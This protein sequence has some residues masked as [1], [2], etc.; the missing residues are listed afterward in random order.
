M[1]FQ[2]IGFANDTYL[3]N[4]NLVNRLINEWDKYGYLIVAFDFDDTVYSENGK[5]EQVIEL[6][7]ACKEIGCI[8]IAFTCRD[9]NEYDF[10]DS[11][12]KSVGIE[13]DYINENYPEVKLDTSRKIFYNIFLDDRC[14]LSAAY[15]T[16][17]RVLYIK[18]KSNQTNN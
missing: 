17:V 2:E 11:Y 12:L 4:D 15:E 1:E 8:L 16:L 7:K 10:V 18:N 5:H 14:G 6:L 9:E 13:Y 3:Q